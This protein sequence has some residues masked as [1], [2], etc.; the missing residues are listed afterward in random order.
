MF[1]VCHRRAV[2]K[3][4]RQDSSKTPEKSEIQR[5]VSSVDLFE[6]SDQENIDPG[7]DL[8]KQYQG[9]KQ[10]DIEL[11]EE[12]T[13]V[14]G[15]IQVGVYEGVCNVPCKENRENISSGCE[16]D[17][18]NKQGSLTPK[19]TPIKNLP[20]SPSQVSGVFFASLFEVFIMFGICC[21]FSEKM[22]KI[23]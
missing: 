6:H 3:T 16:Y 11:V 17:I 10:G 21:F 19:G 2:E 7:K 5:K 15:Y 9:E 23:R 22:S 4:K 14:A 20:F 8:F 12:K 18:P 1:Q 13:S